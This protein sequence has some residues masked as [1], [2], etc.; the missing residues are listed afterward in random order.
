MAL[1]AIADDGN[2][3]APDNSEIGVALRDRRAFEHSLPEG[4]EHNLYRDP[5]K[6]IGGVL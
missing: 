6:D 5:G 4:L 2:F 3:F 1:I